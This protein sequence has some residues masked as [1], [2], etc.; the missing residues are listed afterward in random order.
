MKKIIKDQKVSVPTATNS[1]G[2]YVASFGTNMN[3]AATEILRVLAL[4]KSDAVL[5]AALGVLAAA[6]A[7]DVK[8]AIQDSKFYL[9]DFKG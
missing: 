2:I 4:D 9:H 5:I 3:V 1:Y 6:L 7:Q 8:L